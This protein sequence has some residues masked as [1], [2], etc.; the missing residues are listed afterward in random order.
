MKKLKKETLVNLCDQL[1]SHPWH[2]DEIEELVHPKLGVITGF[3][4]LLDQLEVLRKT[5]LGHTPP[6]MSVQKGN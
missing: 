6:A 3:Q 1:A 2:Y 5:D 4:E